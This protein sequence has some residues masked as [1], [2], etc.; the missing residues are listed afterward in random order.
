MG[1]TGVINLGVCVYANRQ[2]KCP[3]CHYVAKILEEIRVRIRDKTP[4][5]VEDATFEKMGELMSHNGGRILGMYDELTTFLTQINLYRGGGL[6]NSH[7]LALFLQLYNGYSW[8][9]KCNGLLSIIHHLSHP[10]VTGEANFAMAST[11]LTLGG[12]T[13]PAVAR[14]MIELPAN[15]EK[16][17]PQRFIWTFPKPT[18]AEFETLEPSR[19]YFLLCLR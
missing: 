14:S 17:L 13:Q 12:F 7:E 19:S 16:G 6:A 4:W 10:I 5:Q 3:L 1:Q 15:A 2:R 18:Y 11:N 9:R 8:T